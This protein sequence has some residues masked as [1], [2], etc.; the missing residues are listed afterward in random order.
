VLIAHVEIVRIRGDGEGGEFEAEIVF[1]HNR[2]CI[3]LSRLRQSEKRNC[4]N[5]VT[6]Q[7]HRICFV[8]GLPAYS[9]AMTIFCLAFCYLVPIFS[10][11]I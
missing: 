2:D 1:I 3:P 10:R 4:L 9:P 5:L 7:Q 8:I 11:Y 6:I